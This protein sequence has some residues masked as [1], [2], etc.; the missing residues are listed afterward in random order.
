MVEILSLVFWLE[1]RN[2]EKKGV[3][4]VVLLLLCWPYL[5]VVPTIKGDMIKIIFMVLSVLMEIICAEF[6]TVLLY[7]EYKEHQ[8]KQKVQFFYSYTCSQVPEVVL[9]ILV[10]VL[11]FLKN[12]ILIFVGIT[13]SVILLLCIVPC[14]M[15]LL[16][17]VNRKICIID[18]KIVTSSFFLY[19]SDIKAVHFKKN[20]R[21][22]YIMTFLLENK[23]YEVNITDYMYLRIKEFILDRGI[24]IIYK[25]KS[26][27]YDF[28]N[29]GAAAICLGIAMIGG[30]IST[31]VNNV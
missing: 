22:S 23:E 1:R 20:S 4:L 29:Y 19:I 7:F 31:I 11:Y 25:E 13:Q 15:V 30:G 18:N 27:W 28:V 26:C 14:L 2:Y 9:R 21:N 16:A 8:K 17:I 24:E 10:A 6:I 3:F 12:V 5:L